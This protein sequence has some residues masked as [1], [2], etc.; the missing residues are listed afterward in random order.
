[1]LAH[2]AAAAPGAPQEAPQST[3]EQGDLEEQFAA[4]EAMFF[5]AD[6]P[7]SIVLFAALIDQ[8]R[9]LAGSGRTD[10]VPL[11]SRGLSYRAQAN[12][13]LGDEATALADLRAMLAVDPSAEVDRDRVSPKFTELFDAIRAET[14]GS[15]SVLVSPLDA[16]LRVDGQVVDWTSGMVAV[17]AG[18]HGISVERLGFETFFDEVE[19]EAGT[20]LPLEAALERTSAVASFTFSPANAEVRLDGRSVALVA[21][22]PGALDPTEERDRSLSGLTVGEHRLEIQREGY[23]TKAHV[24]QIDALE[25]YSLGTID[26][27]PAVGTVVLQN[28]PPDAR[29][30]VD[31]V[32]MPLERPGTREVRLDMLPGAHAVEI[33]AGVRGVFSAAVEVVDREDSLIDVKP[34]PSVAFLGVLG[35]DEFGRST[36]VSAATQSFSASSVWLWQDRAQDAA[37][38]LVE[39]GLVGAA[40]RG[41]SARERITAAR[42]EIATTV[43]ASIYVLAVLDDDLMA[44]RVDVFTWTGAPGP[45]AVQRMSFGLESGRLVEEL[46]GVFG[47][48]LAKRRAYLGAHLVDSAASRYPTVIAI[49]EG[50][51]ASAAGLRLGDEIAAVGGTDLGTVAEL[52]RAVAA[53]GAGPLEFRVVRRAAERTVSVQLVEHVEALLPGA[54]NVPYAMVWAAAEAHPYLTENPLP[55]WVLQLDQAAVLMHMRQWESAVRLLRTIDAPARAGL[56][57]GMVDYWVGQSMQRAISSEGA[58]LGHDDGPLIQPLALALMAALGE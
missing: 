5:S 46:N 30:Q 48:D 55:D 8:M 27:E 51:P 2:L 54:S 37:A 3:S 19:V 41:D 52:D 50:G 4:A 24:F 44:E 22:L 6:Q 9:A 32:D 36:F 49:T 14:V 29:V 40:L 1:M 13:N 18:S 43:R 31:G 42:A 34:R 25:D 20:T 21:G 26:L 53:A 33:D 58:T 45:A 16:S 28:L 11:L 56:G 7:E 23:R 35:D 12:H 57:Q 39:R 17:V 10:V 15:L 38:I 47:F